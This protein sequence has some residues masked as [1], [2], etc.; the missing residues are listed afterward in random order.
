MAIAGAALIALAALVAAPQPGTLRTFHDWTA[1]CDNA[2]SCQANALI[3]DE[4]NDDPL[5]LVI[6]RTGAPLAMASLDI[7]LP[8]HTA[9]GTRLELIVDGAIAARFAAQPRA[10][11]SLPLTGALL[12][13]LVAGHRIALRQP[14][15]SRIATASLAGLAA[16]L[17]YIDDRQHRA[18]THGALV[19]N[20]PNPDSTVPL[21]PH[22]EPVVIPPASTRPPRTI[23]AAQAAA[24]L[25]PEAAV[26]RN[27]DGPL[28]PQA[29]RLDAAHSLVL[30]NHPCGNGAYNAAFTAFVLDETGPPRAALIEGTPGTGDDDAGPELTNAHWDEPT[31]TLDSFDKARGPGDCGLKARYAWDGRRFALIALLA[32][33][34]CRGSVDYIRIWTVPVH[35]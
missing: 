23:S 24:L 7:P 2:L 30:V 26:C 35:G 14:G 34:E 5:M 1:G 10:Q 27:P 20:G 29:H 15:G 6:R 21:P 13:A 3:A 31:R 33:D 22:A 18:G 12:S 4:A 28:R 11:A 32:M 25:D 8:H 9:P 19:A 16:A 17:R